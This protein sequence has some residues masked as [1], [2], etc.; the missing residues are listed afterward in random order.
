MITCVRLTVLPTIVCYILG[1]LE[2]N[3]IAGKLVTCYLGQSSSA[4]VDSLNVWTVDVRYLT[5]NT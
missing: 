4:S 2:T 5:Y 3:L 1:I